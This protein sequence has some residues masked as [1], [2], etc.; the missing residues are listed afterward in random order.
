[1]GTANRPN[2]R[3]GERR[4]CQGPRR[5]YRCAAAGPRGRSAHVGRV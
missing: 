2:G 4:A 5:P 3:F 1:L